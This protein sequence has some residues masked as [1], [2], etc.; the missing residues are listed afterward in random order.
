MRLFQIPKMRPPSHRW[1]GPVLL[2]AGCLLLAGCNLSPDVAMTATTADGE[3]VQV[4]VGLS[5]NGP[6]DDGTVF[7]KLLQ[8][9]PFDM[10]KDKPRAIVF[11]FII[12]FAKGAA[13]TYVKVQDVT[14]EPI[15]DIFTDDHAHLMKKNVW[16]GTSR[17]FA[18]QDEHINWILTL[19]NNTRLYR[20]TVKLA[21]GTTH[22][23]IKALIVPAYM[24]D[25]MRTQLGLKV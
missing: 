11:N 6:V 10:G 5:A 22:K 12:E 15:E 21:D 19:D 20:F 2:A 1:P 14:E 13:P 23:L 18:P 3:K 25:F 8:F 16:G 4:P 24:K 17:P 9:A 7:V